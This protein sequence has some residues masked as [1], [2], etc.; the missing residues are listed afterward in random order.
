MQLIVED[1]G[2]NLPKLNVL[3][4]ACLEV[5]WFTVLGQ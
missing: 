5:S 4:F 3:L 2:S 1:L